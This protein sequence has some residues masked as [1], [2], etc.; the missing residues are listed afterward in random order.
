MSPWLLPV[1][2]IVGGVIVSVILSMLVN[3]ILGLVVALL[4]LGGGIW[5][6][7]RVLKSR[8]AP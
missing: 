8:S 2:V 1:S 4:A 5:T 3:P 7:M 6:L